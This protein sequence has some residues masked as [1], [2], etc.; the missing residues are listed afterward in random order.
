MDPKVAPLINGRPAGEPERVHIYEDADGEPVLK[1]RVWRDQDGEKRVSQSVP[2]GKGGWKRSSGEWPDGRPLYRL[3]EL[4][5]PDS[6]EPI[7]VVEGE[8]DA[9]TLAALDLVATTSCM[10][11]GK[12]HL[13]DWSPLA[14]RDVIILP[15]HD[16]PG[17][18]HADQWA[19][20]VTKAGAQK[21]RTVPLPGYPSGDELPDAHGRDISDWLAEDGHDLADLLTAVEVADDWEP[22]AGADH[23]GAE[24][25]AYPVDELP[26]PVLSFVI[27]AARAIGVPPEMVAMPL[28]VDA[29]ACLGNRRYLEL[30][31]G[32]RQWPVLSAANRLALVSGVTLAKAAFYHKEASRRSLTTL[33]P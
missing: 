5:A 11:A 28:L 18:S 27:E 26:E 6:V 24:P 14:G 13:T 19:A 15:D 20:M 23:A 17:F 31:G 22:E 16:K 29:A 30:K 3:P 21:V 4:L 8:K 1:V 12:A 32:F 9:D 2:S 10:G 33:G 7:Y 25:P